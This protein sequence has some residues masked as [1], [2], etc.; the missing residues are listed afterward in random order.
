MCSRSKNC[1]LDL[2]EIPRGRGTLGPFFDFFS[3][4]SPSASALKKFFGAEGLDFKKTRSPL[5]NLRVWFSL[6]QP[7][8]MV[9]KLLI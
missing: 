3:N 8:P 5:D 4:R 1:G 2:F 9:S 7:P 6:M